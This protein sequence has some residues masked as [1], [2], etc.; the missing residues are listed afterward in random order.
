MNKK[1]VTIL[2]ITLIL[3]VIGS[4]AMNGSFSD[5]QILLISTTTSLEDTGLLDELETS[6]E[7]KYPNIDVQIIS[8]GTGIA[9]EY[10]KKGDADL[11]IVHDKKREIE[12]VEE[13]FGTKRYPFAYNYFYILGP[14]D[15]PAKI[16]GM[17][18]ATQAFDMIMKAGAT[19]PELVKF[20]SRGDNSGTNFRELKI[21]N[22]TGTDYNQSVNGTQWYV[23]TGKGMGDTLVIAN[24][25]K[26][27]TLSDSGTFLAYKGEIKLVPCVTSG[28]DLLNVYTAIPVN[29]A[30]IEGTNNEAAMKFV[31][32]LLSQEG[33]KLIGNYGK[34]KYGKNLF[35][36]LFG[37][38]E[39]NS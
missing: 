13:G 37:K 19:N 36:P 17:D 35:T 20:V 6:F 12:F 23:E 3:I 27:Y 31:D 9:L 10:G 22:N 2:F 28:K 24:E 1:L 29:T 11:V 18:N 33:Q 34:D 25:K 4:F 15:D 14:A 32:F 39:P 16:K 7:R 8:A 26:A 5:K 21:W 30:K 38:S